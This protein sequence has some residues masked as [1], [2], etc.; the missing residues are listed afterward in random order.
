MSGAERRYRPDRLRLGLDPVRLLFSASPWRAAGF[1]LSYLLVSGVLFSIA[2]T[3]SVVAVVLGFTLA[4]V[5]LL[6]GVAW[7]VRGCASVERVRLGLVLA[8]PPVRGLYPQPLQ[9]GL[10]RRARQLWSAGTTWRDLAY[11]VGLWAP[12]LALDTVVFGLW[13]ELLAG[14]TVPVWYRHVSDFCAGSCTTQ[15]VQGLMIGDFPHG[16]HAAGA[17]GLYIDSL[18]AAVLLALAFA[19]AFLL[20]NYVLVGAARLHGRIGRALLGE[21]ADPLGP[22]KEVLASPGPLGPLTAAGH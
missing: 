8:W 6:I 12:L 17:H 15:H 21:P 18:P 13:A 14:I 16:P 4:A 10:W 2:L 1:L 22:A 20:F 3:A 9:A 19:I 7:L 5:P 11:L